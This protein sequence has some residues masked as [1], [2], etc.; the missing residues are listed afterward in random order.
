MKLTSHLFIFITIFSG[1]WLD[2]LISEFN[3]RTYISLLADLPY[4]AETCIG[5]LILCYW[6]YA[7]PEKIQVSSALIYGLL[8]DLF[9]GNAIG[10]H[11]LFF[12]GIS[13]VIHIY[14]FRFR[15]FSYLQLIIFFAG[16]T[17]F[18]LASKYLLFSPENYSYLLLFFSFF[19]NAFLWLPIYFCMRSMRRHFL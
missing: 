15:L 19:I 12:V 2:N 14:V 16:S 5:F 8:I 17:I 13:Y 11:M 6:I 3:L 18:Y 9:F 4:L 1:F 7:I 10:F